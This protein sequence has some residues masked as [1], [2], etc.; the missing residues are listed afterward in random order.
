MKKSRED[1]W[2]ELDR[3]EP[4]RPRVTL[5]EALEIASQKFGVKPE[6]AFGAHFVSQISIDCA[7]SERESLPPEERDPV[8]R[9]PRE[10]PHWHLC[11]SVREFEGEH[12]CHWST[13]DTVVVF[14]DGDAWR[15][16]D[17]VPPPPP[18]SG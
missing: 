14:E 5:A 4:T 7:R 8:H 6:E 12:G 16:E 2:R 13:R 10:G 17:L 11:F 3:R 15:F 1:S 18:P 9:W